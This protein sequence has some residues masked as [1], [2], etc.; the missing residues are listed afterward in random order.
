MI[1]D[2]A[3]HIFRNEFENTLPTAKDP[4]CVVCNGE[5]LVKELP[6]S[7]EKAKYFELPTCNDFAA[8][9]AMEQAHFLFRLDGVPY[10][11]LQGL[12]SEQILSACPSGTFA[13]RRYFRF[14]KPKHLSFAGVTALQLAGWYKANTFCGKCATPMIRDDKERMVKCPNCAQMVYPRINPAV[15]I[16][17]YSGN[18]IVLT[19]YRNGPTT[20]FALV[21][22][23]TEIGETLEQ[24]VARE[25]ME[26]VGLKIKNIR[27][28]KSQPWSFTDTLLMGFY[29]ELD[30]DD[31][32]KLEE[33]ELKFG[34][35]FDREKLKPIENND[36]S[37]T[38][39]MIN[40]FRDNPDKF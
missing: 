1:Q 40:Y 2:I 23:F 29:C 5:I 25:V 28:Y 14:A 30:G 39:E 7:T 19:Q 36:L 35:W 38:N 15:I 26:E 11:L 37:L 13:S 18:K 33:N 22:G 9:G 17:I 8:C 34:G 6:E 21:A 24:T 31:T 12:D 27:Y 10:F 32:I 20:N 3:P 16:G 4:I